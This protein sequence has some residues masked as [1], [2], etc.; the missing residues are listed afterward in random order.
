MVLGDLRKGDILVLA[1][2]SGGR[3][4]CT[5]EVL[6]LTG[7]IQ[8]IYIYCWDYGLDYVYVFVSSL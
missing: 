4:V 1:V 8:G 2:V 5:G 7:H 6:K 3:R